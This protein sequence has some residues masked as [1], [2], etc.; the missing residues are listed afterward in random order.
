MQCFENFGGGQMPQIPPGCAPAY[1]YRIALLTLG[2][3]HCLCV[4]MV[5]QLH[6]LRAQQSKYLLSVDFS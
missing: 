3:L 2:T 1:I 5:A 4:C 6:A